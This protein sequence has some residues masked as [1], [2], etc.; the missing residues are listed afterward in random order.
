MIQ[1]LRLSLLT[2]CALLIG[3]CAAL[4]P[5]FE[6]PEVEIIGLEPLPPVSGSDLRFR[7]HLRI[8]NP[9]NQELALSGLYYK[10]NLAGHK[11]LTGTSNRLSPIAPFGQEDISVDATASWMGSLFAIAKLINGGQQSVPYELQAKI[12]LDR[13]IAPA[14]TVRRSGEIQLNQYQPSYH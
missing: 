14:I 7:I 9:N 11:V 5:N 3:G 12:G 13:S 8:F 2:L 4:S 10:L 1:F 6:Q